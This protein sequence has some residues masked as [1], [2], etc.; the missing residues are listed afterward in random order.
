M[1]WLIV[2]LGSPWLHKALA[3][4]LASGLVTSLIWKVV[5]SV[6]NEYAKG[7]I[8]RAFTEVKSAV[9]AVHQTY[10]SE[11]SIARADG[12]LTEAEKDLAKDMAVNEVK[13]YLGWRGLKALG[14]VLGLDASMLDSWLDGK[15][16]TAVAEL[17]AG[18]MLPRGP[19]AGPR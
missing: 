7:V 14:R 3:W 11:I 1:D 4:L 8:Q 9:L 15:V 17:K 16:E 2:T 13:A 5:S 6:R 12:K 19:S 10:V 18:G